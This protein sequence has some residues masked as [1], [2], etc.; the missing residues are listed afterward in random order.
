MQSYERI[1]MNNEIF[2]MKDSSQDC[3][4]LCKETQGCKVWAYV[5]SQ[6]HNAPDRN[7][8]YLGKSGKKYSNLGVDSGY[9]TCGGK[10]QLQGCYF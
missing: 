1:P 10:L 8:C 7:K 2:I 3:R 6:Y 9:A 4:A 5:T